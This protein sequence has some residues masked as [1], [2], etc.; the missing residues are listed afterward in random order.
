MH[1]YMNNTVTYESRKSLYNFFIDEFNFE[2]IE[3]NYYQD[4]F[5]DFTPLLVFKNKKVAVLCI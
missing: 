1:L 4:S 5:G 3:E 2:V